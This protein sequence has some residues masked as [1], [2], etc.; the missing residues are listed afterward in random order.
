MIDALL[1]QAASDAEAAEAPPEGQ[2]NAAAPAAGDAAAGT[3]AVP[4][5]GSPAPAAAPAASEA[6]PAEAGAAAPPSP[7]VRPAVFSPLPMAPAARVGASIDLLMEVPLQVTAELGRTRLS[8]REVLE[9][10]AGSVVELERLAGEPI[11][12]LVN[13]LLIARGEV[14]V[15]DESF[16]IRVTEIVKRNASA[17]ATRAA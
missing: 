11:D 15:I 5:A 9:L 1:Q 17:G 7:D 6:M 16:G 2:A 10:G 3:G 14:V 13:S 4:T 12:L 8:V